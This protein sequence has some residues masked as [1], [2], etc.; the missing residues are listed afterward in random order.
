MNASLAFDHIHLISRDPHAAAGWYC[1]MFGAT[2]SRVQEDL[3]GAPQIDVDMG[4]V[5]IIIR[6]QR[7]GE[8]PAQTQP[9]QAFSGYSS[10]NE[11]GV[12]HF[13]LTYA[14]DLRTFC[15]ELRRKG[16]RMAVEPWEFKPGLV[17]CYVEAPDGVSIE[18]V[19]R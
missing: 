8:T 16:V 2:I 6:G 18:I 10:H 9:M 7:P 17:L 5:T 15:E 13:G 14:G 3:R 1:E 11:W 12:D 19:Q 4:P